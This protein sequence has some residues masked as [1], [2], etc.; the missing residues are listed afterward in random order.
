MEPFNV[1]QYLN[2]QFAGTIKS[3]E[4]SQTTKE[5]LAELEQKKQQAVQY[6]A[7]QQRM[8][9]AVDKSWAG[10]LGV[11]GSFVGDIVDFGASVVSGASRFGGELATAAMAPNA[12]YLL[13]GLTQQDIDAYNRRARGEAT[14]DDVALLSK[15]FAL[16]N[17][18]GLTTFGAIE[19]FKN[20]QQAGMSIKDTM[21]ISSIVDP[22]KRAERTE[23]I[24]DIYDKGMAQWNQE[25]VS[26]KLKGAATLASA[27]AEGA[28][29]HP[30]A[31]IQSI[32]ENLPQLLVGGVGGLAGK[33][34]MLAGNT[35]YGTS[36]FL[37]GMD[38]YSEKNN[39][40]LPSQAHQ[41]KTAS[42]AASLVAAESLGDMIGLHGAGML[43]KVL[44]G[45]G[46]K[47][48]TEGATK[49]FKDAMLN[50]GKGTAEGLI[51]E[52]PTEAYQT[53]AEKKI[54]D[55][56]Q[57]TGKE[58]FTA[59]VEGG[60]SGAGLSG[61]IRAPGEVA[62][63]LADTSM[64]KLPGA[65]KDTAGKLQETQAVQV[66]VKKALET[67]DISALVSIDS[68]TF[69]PDRAIGALF[70]RTQQNKDEGADNLNRAEDILEGMGL[71]RRDLAA[72]LKTPEE[73]QASIDRNQAKM[74]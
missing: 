6:Q 7:N 15:Q 5:K 53:W 8:Q 26:N 16:D 35:G 38:K 29:N 57:A 34:V 51:G 62:S 60:L 25:G 39:G 32:G 33:A 24:G 49:T 2:T 52:T 71:V 40:Q 42:L 3:L 30:A 69:A 66:E 50:I 14:A 46:S 22:T 67:G 13:S 41:A 68:P 48:A 65:V 1:N 70:G 54:V 47:A 31:T 73:I 21:D 56:K 59:G 9:Q 23:A 11:D 12:A 20:I 36:T 27:F 72:T 37:E 18:T 64:P 55:N 74:D 43:G 44:G 4:T 58:I 45:T 19:K 10:K 17:S 61:G 63:W 28:V